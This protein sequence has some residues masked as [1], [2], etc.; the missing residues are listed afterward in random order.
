LG[1]T[2]DE[3]ALFSYIAYRIA[4]PRQRIAGWCCDTKEDIAAFVGVTRA[5]L[6]K[7]AERMILEGLLD[8]GG[9][10]PF[11]WKV[12]AKW[13]DTENDCKQSLQDFVNKVD[14]DCKQSLHR[15]VNKVYTHNKV[16]YDISKSKEEK[17][18]NASLSSSASKPET[19][20]LKA[21][22]KTVEGKLPAPQPP[23]IAV[24]DPDLPGVTLYDHIPVKG[25]P[26]QEPHGEWKR[27]NIPDEIQRLK[28]DY[29]AK[30]NFTRSRRIPE[31]LFLEYIE[32]FAA[33]IGGT[34]ETYANVL[35]FRK[36]FFNWSLRRFEIAQRKAAQPK[37][38]ISNGQP[39]K[40]RE[41]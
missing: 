29:L 40:I 38:Q 23:T 9:R 3:Y 19:F 32:T 30:E 16:E 6:Y 34:G 33:E 27:V 31:S 25:Y 2:R 13:I 37:P 5:G 10:I 18:K 17:E 36:H 7:M 15:T 1:I 11:A 12:T 28:G 21:E 39:Y 35:A 41:L 14:T 4:D 26:T 24:I 20:P 8:V 22:K